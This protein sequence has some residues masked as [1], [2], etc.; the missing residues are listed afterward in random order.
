MVEGVSYSG[1][2]EQG[3]LF[4][5][6]IFAALPE[7]E[8]TEVVVE[9]GSGFGRLARIMRLAGRTKCFVLADLPESLLFA[10]AFLKV[11]LPDARTHVIKSP[12]DIAP[13]MASEYDFIFCPIQLLAELRLDT[14]D[15]V[16]NTYSLSEMTQGCTD[17]L[18]HCIHDVLRPR[19]LFSLNYMFTDK[20]IHFDTGGL[21]GEANEI[22]LKLRPE[23]QPLRFDLMPS[24]GEWGYRVAGS[25]VLRHVAPRSVQKS[26]DE[27]TQAASK[28]ER[29]SPEWLGYMYLA[30]LW[31]DDPVI[32]EEFFA[33]LRQFFADRAIDARP[34]FNFDNI[35]EVKFLRRRLEMA[36]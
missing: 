14:V 21:D 23:W 13:Q 26:I 36:A 12:A 32:I 30:A 10:Y 28:V 24:A 35:G 29:G 1:K 5:H 7:N 34:E 9:I 27:M 18:M 17:H 3:F 4:Y 33:G 15:L 6:E 25:V 11:N 22:V 31:A 16:I 20:S 8:P 19:F 2:T